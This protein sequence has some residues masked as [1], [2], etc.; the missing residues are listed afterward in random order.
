MTESSLRERLARGDTLLGT[1][2]TLPSPESAEILAAAGFDWLFID[3]EHSAMSPRDA[4]AIL[5]GVGKRAACLLRVPLND[6]IWIKKALD[7]GAEGVIIPLVKTAAE[8]EQAVRLSKY[9]NQG[10]RSIGYGRAHG[11]GLALQDY[12]DRAN[13]DTAVVVQVEHIEA[14]R[15]LD[16]I[17][18]VDGLD[19][20]FI[21]PYDLSASMGHLGEINHPEV[22]E[23][24]EKV[25]AACLGCSMPLGILATSSLQAKAY[26]EQGYRLIACSAD[27]LLLGNAAR[28]VVKDFQGRD[29]GQ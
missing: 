11:Y 14:V 7:T 16:A 21:G 27:A 23:A 17:L 3:L 29:P 5:Q 1:L 8:A 12:L 19:A 18:H 22:L 26:A 10:A 4:Q 2:V 9:P 6:E 15:N 13:E 20:L 24:V 25:R 28:A